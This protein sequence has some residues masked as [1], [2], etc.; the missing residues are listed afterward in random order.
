ML[1]ILSVVDEVKNR[2]KYS[3]ESQIVVLYYLCAVVIFVLLYSLT[4]TSYVDRYNIP[5]AIFAIPVLLFWLKNKLNGKERYVCCLLC[6]FLVTISSL[7]TYKSMNP[8]D[9]NT[10]KKLIADILNED[11]YE[12]GYA[13]FW[14]ANVMTELSNGKI[15]M[16]SWWPHDDKAD[17]ADLE[18]LYPW[19][20]ETKN[21]DTVPKG[22]VFIFLSLDEARRYTIAQNLNRDAVIY[23]SDEYVIY[24]YKN[25]DQLCTDINT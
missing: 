25:Y 19:L 5:I 2:E 21:W 8:V 15:S 14:N 16:R 13:T 3:F 1:L 24:G 17:V 20:Q 10:E 9:L 12:E 18:T 6:L 7:C 11:G 22:K 23:Q 4:D